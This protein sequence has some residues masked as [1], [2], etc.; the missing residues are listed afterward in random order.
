MVVTALDWDAVE[1]TGAV[2]DPATS[3]AIV[4]LNLAFLGLI[5]ERCA[6]EPER[7][8]YGLAPRYAT[9]VATLGA[10]RARRVATCP[11]T[12]FS[13]RLDEMSSWVTGAPTVCL[14]GDAPSP[15]LEGFAR[16]VAFFV[17]H[18][19]RR[20]PMTSALVLGIGPN[21]HAR[22]RSLPL[23]SVDHIAPRIV[24]TLGARWAKHTFFWRW[25]LREAGTSPRVAS[26]PTPLLG[27]QL[28]A[29]E[30]LRSATV[31]RGAER[32]AVR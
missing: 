2:L 1:P 21:T 11:Y 22:W 18:L 3:E 20:D 16:S 12:L 27:L 29:A 30:G 31:R 6:R 13:L 7:E 14:P 28:L 32:H 19:S 10:P 4:E 25:L 5:A 24:S 9:A 8:A 23:A 15:A 26:E 17:W